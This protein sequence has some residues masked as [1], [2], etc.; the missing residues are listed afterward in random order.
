MY[1]TTSIGQYFLIKSN[2]STYT[3]SVGKNCKSPKWII[4]VAFP[5]KNADPLYKSS[6]CICIDDEES[7][8]TGYHLFYYKFQPSKVKS[9][10]FNFS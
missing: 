10:Y 2:A 4:T 3:D 9:I 8:I 6:F 7:G 1:Q 5:I